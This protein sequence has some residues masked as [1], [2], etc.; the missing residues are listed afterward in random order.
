VSEGK[1]E[2]FLAL[3]RR[4]VA[5]AWR[6]AAELAGALARG[7]RSRAERIAHDL[8]GAGGGYRFPAITERA[9]A[10]EDGIRGGAADERLAGAAAEVAA[11][12]RDAAR[13]VEVALYES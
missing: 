10:V 2:R 12:V 5:T 8:R 1:A 9:A 6:S 7:E 3:Q 4:F 11:A 13:A